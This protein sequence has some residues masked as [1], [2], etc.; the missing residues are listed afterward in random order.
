MVMD[1]TISSGSPPGEGGIG[2]IRL[3]G[4][5]SL[6]IAEKLFV[7]SKGKAKTNSKTGILIMATYWM[8]TEYS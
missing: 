1:D 3:S 2:V 5:E 6:K 4:S 8:R 7:N